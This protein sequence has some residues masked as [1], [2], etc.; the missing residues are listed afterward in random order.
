MRPP[1]RVQLL[2]HRAV[3]EPQPVLKQAVAADRD[4]IAGG[5]LLLELKELAVLA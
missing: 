3:L 4:R 5:L 1:G 2:R